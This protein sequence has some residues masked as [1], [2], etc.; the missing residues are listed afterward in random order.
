MQAHGS[1]RPCLEFCGHSLDQPGI[2]PDRPDRALLEVSHE[3]HVYPSTCLKAVALPQK[4]EKSSPVMTKILPS[5]D[6]AVQ[7]HQ[8][9]EPRLCRTAVK[10]KTK[11]PSGGAGGK[12]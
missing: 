5:Q 8:Q 11:H 9:I 1:S 6:P 7:A 10:W 12:R 3:A 2:G 4:E